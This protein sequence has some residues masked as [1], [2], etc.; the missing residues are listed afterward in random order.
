MAQGKSAQRANILGEPVPSRLTHQQ[1][2]GKRYTMST[3]TAGRNGQSRQNLLTTALVVS[4]VITIAALV[5]AGLALFREDSVAPPRAAT[6]PSSVSPPRP[7][8]V[9]AAADD[10]YAVYVVADRAQAE[11]IQRLLGEGDAI[12]ADMGLQPL[13]R[14]VFV[15]ESEEDAVLIPQLIRDLRSEVGGESV[16]VYDLRRS[17][18]APDVAEGITNG[19]R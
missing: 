10:S 6:A 2:T 18:P 8:R 16:K 11:A 9:N 17:A 5:G 15:S 3:R 13:G 1:R 7:D 19:V 12:R 4:A 14:D